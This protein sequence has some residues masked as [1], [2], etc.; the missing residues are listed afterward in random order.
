MRREGF[1]GILCVALVTPL[2]GVAEVPAPEPVE[3]KAENELLRR[4]REALEAKVRA[5]TEQLAEARAEATSAR[6]QAEALEL[7]CRQLQEQLRTHEG[8]PEGL[9]PVVV[10]PVQREILP[11]PR[12]TRATVARGKVTAI[13]REGRL[14]QV[15]IGSEAGL[16]EGQAIEVF[17]LSDRARHGVPVYLGTLKLV[18]VDAQESLGEFQ[19]FQGL[20]RRPRIGDDVASELSAR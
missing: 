8:H 5:L 14:V 15:S 3:L 17:R 13:G 9:Q 20:D 7:R 18:R 12:V 4:E 1:L 6:T 2:V 19:G 10:A 16:H 11:I